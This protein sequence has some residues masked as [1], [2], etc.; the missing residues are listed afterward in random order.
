MRP[1]VTLCALPVAEYASM[2]SGLAAEAF[3]YSV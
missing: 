3:W 2:V 1:A